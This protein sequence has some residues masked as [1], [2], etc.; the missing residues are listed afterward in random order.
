LKKQLNSNLYLA[1]IHYPV[2]NKNGENIV[3]A[4][5]NLDLHDIA[6]AAKTYGVKKFYIVTPLNDQKELVYKILSHW[7][8]GFGSK[9]NPKRSEALELIT[10]CDTL[11]DVLSRKEFSEEIPKTIVTSAKK[12]LNNLGYKQLK[13]IIHL[14]MSCILIFGTAWGIS[15][16]VIEKADFILEPISGNTEYNHLSVRSAVSIILDRLLGRKDI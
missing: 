6:R 11:D 7:K 9:Y 1:L 3:S 4:I 15:S 14:G 5:T 12:G 16:S 13:D 8:N 10:V 2:V